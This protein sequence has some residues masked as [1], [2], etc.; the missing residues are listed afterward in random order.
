MNQVVSA[1]RPRSAMSGGHH[2]LAN[3]NGNYAPAPP[4]AIAPVA[5]APPPAAPVAAPPAAPPANQEFVRGCKALVQYLIDKVLGPANAPIFRDPVDGRTVPDYYN[6]IRRPICLRDILHKLDS[7]QYSSPADFYLDMNQ[8]FENCFTYN[9]FDSPVGQMGHRLETAFDAA[10]AKLPFASS[11]PP[12]PPRNYRYAYE[13]PAKRGGFGAGR[14]AG[15]APAAGG[16]GGAPR[17]RGRVGRPPGVTRTKSVNS[18]QHLQPLP[19]DKA[20]ELATAMTDE[21]VMEA[22]MNGVVEILQAAN[23]LPTNEDGEIE[24]DISQ[25]SAPVMWKLYE[26]VIGGTVPGKVAQPGFGNGV[27]GAGGF[28]I[29]GEDSDYA[30][31]EDDDE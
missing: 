7:A 1:K 27:P 29:D 22:K 20:Q 13:Q 24:L 4:P 30:P 2:H 25:L 14:G 21:A 12:K 31:E 18:Y 16:F 19:Q 9:V 3:G 23:E 15:R 5:A 26:F 17:G 28:Q 11:A 6:I 8:L 10:W